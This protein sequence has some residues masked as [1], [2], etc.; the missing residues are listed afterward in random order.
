[1]LDVLKLKFKISHE[2]LGEKKLFL[3]IPLEVDI[4]EF[5]TG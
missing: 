5:H 1:M 3:K 4:Q 2:I